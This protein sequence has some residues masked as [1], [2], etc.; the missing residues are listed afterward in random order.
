MAGQL[1]GEDKIVQTGKTIDT[2]RWVV[3][4]VTPAETSLLKHGLNFAVT[5]NKIL[6]K[7][8]I[9]NPNPN[10]HRRSIWQTRNR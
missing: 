3:N 6:I 4:R 10:P 2:N 1:T 9:K 5:P 8:H 7:Q